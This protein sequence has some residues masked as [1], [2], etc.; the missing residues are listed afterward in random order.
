M[1]P[2][3]LIPALAIAVLAL[4]GCGDAPSPQPSPS[5][6]SSSSSPTPSASASAS[7]TP[8]PTASASPSAPAEP[9]P[10]NSSAAPVAEPPA[11]PAPEAPEQP[12]PE[13]GGGGVQEFFQTGGRCISDVWSS[14][15]PYT[16]S[17][18]QQVIDYCAA[19]KLGDWSH[20]IDP[21]DPRNYGG[22]ESEAGGNSASRE[23][24]EIARCETLDI[25]TAMSGDIQYC[26]M[27]Y[28]ISVGD[29]PATPD[30]A[31]PGGQL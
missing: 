18:H 22:G 20:G 6:S 5:A 7:S 29:P 4:A 11:A 16:E 28:G 12:G 3:R 9:E 17:L 27:E 1:R 26:Y 19:N 25:N 30:V 14:S 21:M 24:E 23:A 31:G 10:V 8:S 15:L 13:A 2:N